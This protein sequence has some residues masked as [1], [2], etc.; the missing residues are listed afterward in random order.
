MTRQTADVVFMSTGCCG[1]ARSYVRVNDPIQHMIGM[2][3]SMFMH[4]QS[5]IV[6]YQDKMYADVVGYMKELG[7]NL[8]EV[9]TENF[10]VAVVERDYS[11]FQKWFKETVG[12]NTSHQPN[13][14]YGT[15]ASNWQKDW[16]TYQK[17]VTDK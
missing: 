4:S 6:L 1:V 17:R 11:Q 12:Y 3:R 13:G 16:E 2:V 7:I 9:T 15:R 8:S 14:Y 5:Q 10:T